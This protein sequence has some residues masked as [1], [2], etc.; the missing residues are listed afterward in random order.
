MWG[1]QGESI[2]KIEH[3]C[4]SYDDLRERV[5]LKQ[6]IFILVMRV[7]EGESTSRTGHVYSSYVRS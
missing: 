2:P 4:C 7:P 5:Y 6:D 3:T 1:L